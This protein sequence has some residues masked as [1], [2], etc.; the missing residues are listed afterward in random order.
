MTRDPIVEEVRAARDALARK[1]EYDI[2]AIFAALRD[3][4]AKDGKQVVRLPARPV[5]EAAKAA[6]RPGAA[7]D[8][9]AGRS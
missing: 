6:A 7:A 9:P 1:H 8:G 4:E 5:G 2:D 3:S